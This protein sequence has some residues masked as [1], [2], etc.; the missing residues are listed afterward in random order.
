M[1]WFSFRF[2]RRLHNWRITVIKERQERIGN[3]LTHWIFYALKEV[4]TQVIVVL[5]LVKIV[6]W[7]KSHYLDSV[8]KK[9]KKIKQTQAEG[10]TPGFTAP[11]HTGPV[12]DSTWRITL[13]HKAIIDFACNQRLQKLRTAPQRLRHPCCTYPQL[14]G[15]VRAAGS[16]FMPACHEDLK[17]LFSLASSVSQVK[18]GQLSVSM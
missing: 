5:S 8:K 14:V 12:Q 9:I 17:I 6:F 13:N 7:R 1:E 16:V 4:R 15:V 18:A 2:R 11:T 3:L 10:N